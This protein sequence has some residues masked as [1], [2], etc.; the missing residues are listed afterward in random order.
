MNT[1]RPGMDCRD[2]DSKDGVQSHIPV[3]WIPAIHAGMTLNLII[4][5]LFEWFPFYL[6]Y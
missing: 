5:F 4:H 1:R 3:I 6:T 2:P